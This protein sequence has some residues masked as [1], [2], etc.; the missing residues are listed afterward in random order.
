MKN[1]WLAPFV[2]ALRMPLLAKEAQAHVLGG[3][4]TGRRKESER[5]VTEKIAA[6][7][8][9]VMMA[10]LE[11]MRINTEIGLMA[12]RGEFGGI[13]KVLRNGA[14]RISDAASAPAEKRMRSN[15]RRLTPR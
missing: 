11:A 7:N 13:S 9:G 6:V 14:D 8:E 2:V 4:R 15:I 3:G 12:M 10:S 1:Y 5:M